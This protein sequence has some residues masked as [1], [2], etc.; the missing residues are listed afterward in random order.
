MNKAG[1]RPGKIIITQTDIHKNDVDNFY[2]MAGQED[3][4]RF[5]KKAA[6]Y[7]KKKRHHNQNK[8]HNNQ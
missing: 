7:R 1:K 5:D 6:K 3:M 4:N 2:N 8:Q